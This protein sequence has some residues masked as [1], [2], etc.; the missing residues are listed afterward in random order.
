MDI[1]FRGNDQRDNPSGGLCDE[2]HVSGIA[3]FTEL[4]DT[5]HTLTAKHPGCRPLF[6][7]DDRHQARYTSGHA[8]NNLALDTATDEEIAALPAECFEDG[9]YLGYLSS[10]PEFGICLRNFLALVAPVTFADACAHGLVLDE[11]ALQEWEDYQARPLALLDQPMSALIVPVTQGCDALAAFP[12]GYFTSDLDP[13]QN[14]A[15]ARH[16][17][18]AQ[19][20]ELIG[21]GAAYLGFLRAEPASSQVAQAVAQDLCA[22][23]NVADEQCEALAAVFA[24]AIDGREYLWVRYVE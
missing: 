12:N 4:N 11:P 23:Y 19:G 13:A 22:L 14:Y 16:L 9:E 6:T 24:G 7:L 20:Y 2:Y 15:V 5:Y 21:V 10:K 18:L 17:A 8:R 1:E 3:S